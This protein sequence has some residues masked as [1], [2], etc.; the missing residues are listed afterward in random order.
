[1]SVIWRIANREFRTVPV[2]P[3]GLAPNQS[4]RAGLSSFR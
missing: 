3:A 2:W 4:V 1:M